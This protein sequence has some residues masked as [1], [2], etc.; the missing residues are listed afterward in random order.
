MQLPGTDWNGCGKKAKREE[1]GMMR[2][3]FLRRDAD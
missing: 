1:S 3:Q 2:E